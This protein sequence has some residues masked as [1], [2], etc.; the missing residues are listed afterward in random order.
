MTTA[1]PDP[2]KIRCGHC[3]EL[4]TIDRQR[5]LSDGTIF[6]LCITQVAPVSSCE[7]ISHLER[8]LGGPWPRLGDWP[9]PEGF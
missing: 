3:G 8:C 4:L 5:Y 2:Q 9:R 6:C 7:D 1:S